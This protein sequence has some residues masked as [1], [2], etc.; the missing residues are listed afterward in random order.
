MSTIYVEADAWEALPPAEREAILDS[1]AP[2]LRPVDGAE[3]WG[4]FGTDA[5]GNV[6]F[7]RTDE[8]VG[9]RWRLWDDPRLIES[10]AVAIAAG[11]E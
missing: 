10:Q 3:V 11:V 4:T 6:I 8:G 1:S 5:E 7:T 9:Q 2:G